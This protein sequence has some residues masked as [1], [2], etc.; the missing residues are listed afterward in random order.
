[1]ENESQGLISPDFTPEQLAKLAEWSGYKGPE[2]K[3]PEP[4][5]AAENSPA[6]DAAADIDKHFP[7]G[8]LEEFKIPKFIKGESPTESDV[9]LIRQGQDWL[10][11]GRFPAAQGSFI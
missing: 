9:A 3:A 10:S 1:M 11:E 6:Q 8:R 7:P 5:T 4:T 2:V